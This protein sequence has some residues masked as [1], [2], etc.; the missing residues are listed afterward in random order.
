MEA[1]L[2]GNDFVA[3][4]ADEREPKRVLVRL[5][6]TVDEKDSREAFGCKRQKTRGGALTHFERHGIRLKRQLFRLPHHGLDDARMAEAK[7]GNGM[8]S[9][10]VENVSALGGAK[11]HTLPGDRLQRQLRVDVEKR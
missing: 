4:G 11:V 7:T 1:V 5:G 9:I 2:D 10:K 8:A 6:A 3:I